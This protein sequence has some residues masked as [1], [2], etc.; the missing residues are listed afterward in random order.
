M[1]YRTLYVASILLAGAGSPSDGSGAGTAPEGRELRVLE[2][3]IGS[4][5]GEV[6]VQPA[7]G[8]ESTY[9]AANTYSWALG[10]RFARDEGGDATGA[11]SFLGM[12]TYDP[13]LKA[14][15]SW[16]FQ[17]PGG[18]VTAFTYRWVE[19][20]QAFR[21]GADLGGG[22]TLEAEDRFLGKDA[23]EWRIVLKDKDGKA[24][25]RMTGRMKR[26]P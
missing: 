24:L 10:G 1:R 26:A 9:V 6:S 2:R 11:T 7:G 8:R 23:Y 15:R 13:G 19:R 18:E 16:Y 25:N 5:K 22:M 20:D 21:G 4:W 12:W 14:Y 17:A 3:F